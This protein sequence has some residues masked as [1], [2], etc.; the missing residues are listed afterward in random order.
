[1]FVESVV[2]TLLKKCTMVLVGLNIKYVS[3]RE[4]LSLPHTFNY[5]YPAKEA[6]DLYVAITSSPSLCVCV[7][8]FQKSRSCGL[9]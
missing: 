8:V 6:R 5:Y 3:T 2:D 1:M 7:C 4:G 9:R